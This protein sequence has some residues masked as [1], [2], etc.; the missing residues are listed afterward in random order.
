MPVRASWPELT[1]RALRRR[2]H[3][4]RH[5]GARIRF[6]AVRRCN[7]SRSRTDRRRGMRAV[8]M[9]MS[10]ALDPHVQAFVARGSLDVFIVVANVRRANLALFELAHREQRLLVGADRIVVG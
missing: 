3:I 2:M 4:R 10:F 8:S 7:V 6:V 1:S 9:P 5:V